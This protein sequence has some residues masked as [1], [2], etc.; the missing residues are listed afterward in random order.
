MI[1]MIMVIVTWTF[2]CLIIT[3]LGLMLRRFYVTNHLVINGHDLWLSFWGGY[4]LVIGFLQVYHFFSPVNFF[5]T[6]LITFMGLYGLLI[7]KIALK[8]FFR[9]CYF[10]PS[11]MFFILLIVLWLSNKVLGPP[12]GDGGLYHLGVL[13]W[14]NNY[15]LIPGLG[16][17]HTRFAFNN[18]SLLL[19]GLFD[20][21]YWQGRSFHIVNG[22]PVVI[23]FV[24][25][26][27]NI[28][29]L[30][31]SGEKIPKMALFLMFL[32]TPLTAFSI[33]LFNLRIST[34]NTDIPATLVAMVATWELYRLMINRSEEN[35]SINVSFNYI[36]ITMLLT[37]SVCF[38]LSTAVFAFTMYIIVAWFYFESQSEGKEFSKSIVFSCLFISALL[39]LPWMVRG[40]ILSGY[41]LFP[42]QLFS[43][44][45]LW[46]IPSELVSIASSGIEEH[47]MPPVAQE[48]MKSETDWFR[49]WIIWQVT[50]CPELVILPVGIIIAV[51]CYY[52][53]NRKHFILNRVY[54]LMIPST[55]GIIFWFFKAPAPRFGYFMFWIIVSLLLTEL[56]SKHI[57]KKQLVVRLL[58]ASLILFP[59]VHR[60]A[61]WLY[62]GRADKM[63]E[64]L[65]I[66]PGSDGGFHAAPLENMVQKQTSSGLFVNMPA[67]NDR[68]WDWTQPCT[69]AFHKGLS[70]IK[71]GDVQSG[72]K[73]S[74]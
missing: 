48:M 21:G 12:V 46:R 38:K 53:V 71:S 23:C 67:K 51:C 52:L 54:L 34:P 13:N 73:I 15:S 16:N 3:G 61:A 14:N 19:P 24:M 6:L 58:V 1:S 57:R 65:W 7:N 32:I 42:L 49:P 20:F 26:I 27:V 41:P 47:F 72:F 62:M 10:S 17:L 64:T 29:K 18:S 30:F 37:L 36:I 55:F 5:A 9:E 59:I 74:K 44:D 63:L 28:K 25:V 45:V 40:I 8:K 31:Y 50:R 66:L 70:L 60:E 35:K 39:I 11:L 68:C 69:P 43:F 56:I 22:L 4:A 2:A 33:G